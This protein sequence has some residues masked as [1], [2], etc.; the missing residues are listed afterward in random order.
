MAQA[1]AALAALHGALGG[2]EPTGMDLVGFMQQL[3]LNPRKPLK[4]DGDLY[5]YGSDMPRETVIS[6]WELALTNQ[7]IDPTDWTK[8]VDKLDWQVF[9]SFMQT[10][11]FQHSDLAAMPKYVWGVPGL[12]TRVCL[13]VCGVAAWGAAWEGWGPS[14][15]R[16]PQL[17]HLL[18]QTCPVCYCC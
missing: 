17:P 10:G 4:L 12:S 6:K 3:G 7:N 13:P 11:N 1:A 15:W 14:S 5:V 18:P 8:L 9:Q 2:N 16:A